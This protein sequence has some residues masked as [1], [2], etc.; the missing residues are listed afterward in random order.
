MDSLPS[1]PKYTTLSCL[2][3]L[4]LNEEFY[5]KKWGKYPLNLTNRLKQSLLT[6]LTLYITAC[7]LSQLN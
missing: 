4:Y 3:V 7:R 5:D 6:L 1:N 2:N